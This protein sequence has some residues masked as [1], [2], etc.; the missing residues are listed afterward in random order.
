MARQILIVT[1]I[2]T[3]TDVQQ[4]G[5]VDQDHHRLGIKIHNVIQIYEDEISKY[6]RLFYR[7]MQ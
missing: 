6:A 7:T 1:D 3:H 4:N 2:H 5:F